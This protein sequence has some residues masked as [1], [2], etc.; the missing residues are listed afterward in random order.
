MCK[1]ALA[2]IAWGGKKDCRGAS[3]VKRPFWAITR[4]KTAK[5]SPFAS[6]GRCHKTRVFCGTPEGRSRKKNV[7]KEIS[8]NQAHRS[9]HNKERTSNVYSKFRIA[10][11]KEI[12]ISSRR[13]EHLMNEIS[14]ARFNGFRLSKTVGCAPGESSPTSPA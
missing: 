9:S 2:L 3:S 14:E 8:Q 13:R 4:R 1:K 5:V 11:L 10:L 12:R 7:E 6:G